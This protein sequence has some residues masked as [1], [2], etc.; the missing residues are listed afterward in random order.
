MRIKY[1]DFMEWNYTVK[2]GETAML[3]AN[4]NTKN[5]NAIGKM[6]EE[7]DFSAIP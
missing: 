5:K 4:G 3:V 2:N 6:A 1:Y 7:F